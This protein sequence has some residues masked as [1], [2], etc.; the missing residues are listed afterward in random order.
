MLAMVFRPGPKLVRPIMGV[1]TYPGEDAGGGH[2][3]RPAEF[4]HQG[5]GRGPR[6]KRFFVLEKLRKL[7]KK[8]GG[9]EAFKIY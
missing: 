5:L 4:P 6:C 2:P 9:Q 3:S 1:V 7:R 8:S